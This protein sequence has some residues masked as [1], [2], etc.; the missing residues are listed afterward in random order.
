MRS[1]SSLVTSA[2][3]E[4]A[5][6]HAPSDVSRAGI[7]TTSRRRLRVASSRAS[8]RARPMW[9]WRGTGGVRREAG[10][11]VVLTDQ[12]GGDVLRAR[13]GQGDQ[14]APRADGRQH[15]L[16]GR[17]A[18]HPD[19]ALGRLLDRL[20]QRVAGLVGE[21]VGV[22]DDH[23]LPA[24]ADRGERRAADQVAD[25]V[26]A[27]GE[28]LGAHDGDVGVGAGLHR[29]AGVAGVAALL[30]ALERGGQRDR[31]VGPA[32]AGR[33]GEQPGVAHPVARGARPSSPPPRGPGRR[34]C[35]RR[36]IASWPG[37]GAGGRR[38]GRWPR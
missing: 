37:R 26:D 13:R 25:L 21:P 38:P 32:G 31:G 22:L 27:D 15:V 23:H 2:R 14:P 36:V 33:P 4:A 10:V 18:Q 28:L 5:V 12:E 7:E 3:F 9:P 30:L 1:A 17:G 6:M 16:D 11:D 35:P 8:A 20:E 29:V 24:P 34:G 19:G